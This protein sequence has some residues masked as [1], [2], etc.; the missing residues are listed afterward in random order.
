MVTYMEYL[1]LKNIKQVLNI[2]PVVFNEHS[3]L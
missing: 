3:K 1:N 2:Y